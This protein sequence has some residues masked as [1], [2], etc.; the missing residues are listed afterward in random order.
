MF[1]QMNVGG[2]LDSV[3]I[4]KQGKSNPLLRDPALWDLLSLFKE[5]LLK[6]QH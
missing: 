3:V 5:S 4:C 6:E 2:V 1:I